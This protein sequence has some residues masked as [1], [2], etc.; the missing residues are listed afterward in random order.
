MARPIAFVLRSVP[1]ERAAYAEA[2]EGENFVESLAQGSARARVCALQT[3]GELFEAALGEHGIRERDGDLGL[4]GRIVYDLR[5]SGVRHLIQS[6]V[7]PHTVMAAAWLV[8]P[9]ARFSPC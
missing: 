3:R 7:D 8:G 4:V 2:L 5:R 6:G 1:I 9:T